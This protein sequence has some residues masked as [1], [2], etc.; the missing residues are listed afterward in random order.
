MVRTG[1]YPRKLQFIFSLVLAISSLAF[2]QYSSFAAANVKPLSSI[3]SRSE[4]VQATQKSST[5][6]RKPQVSTPPLSDPLRPFVSVNPNFAVM[7]RRGCYGD[8]V[9]TEV[10]SD[11][12]VRCTYGDLT[13]T[14]LLLL[15]GDSNANMWLPAIDTFGYI[16][17]VKVLALTRPGCS[18]WSREWIPQSIMFFGTNERVCTAWRDVAVTKGLSANPSLVIPV[19]IDMPVPSSTPTSALTASIQAMVTRIGISRTLFIEP[20]PRFSSGAAM[21]GCVSMRPT[22]LTL[23]E[24]Q[25]RALSSNPITL[26]F[27]QLS[28]RLKIPIVTTKPYFCGTIFCP[29]FITMRSTSWLVYADGNHITPT[30]SQLLGKSLDIGKYIK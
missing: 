20:P 24:V 14:K 19:G 13:S 1:I 18:P 7:D 27:N 11:F 17:H 15:I 3:P 26:T 9:S 23:C 6:F 2:N 21:A 5:E 8:T 16:N 29:I 12:M 28:T 22:A 30:Y 4:V 10:P 25:S